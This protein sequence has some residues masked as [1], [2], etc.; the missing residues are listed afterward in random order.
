M[1]DNIEKMIKKAKKSSCKYFI[2]ALGINFK[3]EIIG[4]KSNRPRFSKYGGSIH[5][6]MALMSKY[7]KRLKTIYIVRVNPKGKI[8]PIDPCKVCQKKADEL[9]IKIM[10]VSQ[11]DQNDF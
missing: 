11:D 6:E 10:S 4:L 2:S 3:D 7:G 1:S 5:A 8:L 9:G